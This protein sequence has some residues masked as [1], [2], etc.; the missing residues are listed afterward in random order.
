MHTDPLAE[1]WPGSDVDLSNEYL[2]LRRN[3]L[4]PKYEH[5]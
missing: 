2:K 1:T 3:R 4:R 5:G